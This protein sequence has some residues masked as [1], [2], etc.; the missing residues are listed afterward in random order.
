M[1]RLTMNKPDDLRRRIDWLAELE[2][3]ALSD[4]ET[5]HELAIK[6]VTLGTVPF[7]KG[8]IMRLQVV[9]QHKSR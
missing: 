3:W 7:R 4:A 9:L 8:K 6:A 2:A 5:L 1:S